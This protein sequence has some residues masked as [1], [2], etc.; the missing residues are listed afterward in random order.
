VKTTVSVPC[1]AIGAVPLIG[2]ATEGMCKKVVEEPVE[3]TLCKGNVDDDSLR[4]FEP[5]VIFQVRPIAGEDWPRRVGIRWAF[6]YRLDGGYRGSNVCTNYH[7]GDTQSGKYELVSHD[8]VR[9]AIDRLD[10]WSGRSNVAAISSEIQWTELRATYWGQLPTRPSPKIY[11]SAGKHHQ[12]ISAQ[13]CEDEPGS[14]DD[15]CG[16][17][18]ERLANLAPMGAFTNVG[19]LQAHPSDQGVNVPFVTDLAP[20]GFPDEQVWGAK[21]S[22]HCPLA[23][24]AAMCFTGGLGS[25]WSASAPPQGCDT[26]TPVYELFDLAPA[27]RPALE[28]G[29]ALTMVVIF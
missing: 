5:V 3:Q 14:C 23:T 8:G 19:E 25:K 6:L 22:C 18:A 24:P 1:A 21:W 28:L 20:L 13:A 11:A 9:W 29:P 26:P 15:D 7:Y 4:S 12:Y 10:L 2:P 27:P 17:G 16:G